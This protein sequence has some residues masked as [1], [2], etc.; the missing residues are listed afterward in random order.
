MTRIQL[1]PVLTPTQAL[2]AATGY[3]WSVMPHDNGGFFAQ[4]GEHCMT[5]VFNDDR[6]FRC[7]D[8]RQGN[9]MLVMVPEG[10]VVGRFARHGRTLRPAGSEETS[11]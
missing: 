7:A 4:S 6:T 9:G 8:I 2:A 10:D 11:G 3:G 5:V 1:E